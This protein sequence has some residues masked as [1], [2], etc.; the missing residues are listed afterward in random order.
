MINCLFL[1]Y[2]SKKG[3]V[4]KFKKGGLKRE[5]CGSRC[6][7]ACPQKILKIWRLKYEV[8]S[9]FRQAL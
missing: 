7:G 6:S 4:K 1:Y 2:L 3:R 5:K 9:I 8:S